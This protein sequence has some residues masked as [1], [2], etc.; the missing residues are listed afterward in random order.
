MK[1]ILRFGFLSFVVVMLA[2]ATWLAVFLPARIMKQAQSEF[3]GRTGRMLTV[4]AGASLRMSPSFGIALNDISVA[5]ASAMAT[6]VAQAK[7]VFIPVSL[8]QAFGLQ[9]PSGK[10]VF[11]TPTFTMSINSEGR[12]NIIL[13]DGATGFITDVNSASPATMLVTFQNGTFIYSDEVNVKSFMLSE[14]D[15][16]ISVDEK[17]EITLKSDAA[18]GGQRVHIQTVVKS[19]SRAFADGSPFDFNL[20]AAA[21][22]FGFSGRVVAAKGIDLAGQATLDTDDAAR[23]FHWLGIDLHG[24]AGKY[25]LSIASAVEIQGPLILLKKADIKFANMKAQGDVSYLATGVRPNLTL[26]LVLDELNAAL[27]ALPVNGLTP[28]GTWN[29]RAFDL[30]DMNALDVQFRIAATQ[31]RSGNFTTGPAEV[32]GEIKGGVL[33]AS[34][35]SETSGKVDIDFDAAQSPP[36]LS[37]NLNLKNVEAKTFMPRFTGMDWLQGALRLSASLNAEGASQAEMISNMNGN[38]EMQIDRAHIEGV[39][40]AGLAAHVQSEAVSGW[41]GEATDPV[42]ANAKLSFADGVATL[43]ENVL[44]APG[45]TISQTGEIDLLRQA[46]NLEATLNLNRGDGKPLKIKV[47]GPWAKPNF[48]LVKSGN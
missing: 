35:S 9:V 24:L 8:I 1:Q 41:E 18:L 43:Q 7:A 6:P 19:L 11:E 48:A 42:V 22:A 46:L 23:L 33:K 29:D 38:A 21:A 17:Q 30:N 20:E 26:A 10:M 47:S 25:P 28:L 44:T 31:V 2:L 39:E 27:Y 3:L 4:A 5:G 32:D 45:V 12:S 13:G 37:L 16:F 14:A 34:I 40:L 36:K 15:G